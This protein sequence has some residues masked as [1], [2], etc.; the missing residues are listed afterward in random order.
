MFV[1]Y[2][3]KSNQPQKPIT[4]PSDI[5]LSQAVLD[6]SSKGNKK[7]PVCLM[8]EYEKKQFIIAV[9]DPSQS[10]QCPLDLM[11]AAGTEVKFYLKGSGTVHLTGFEYIDDYDDLSMSASSDEDFEDEEIT[12]E[13]EEEEAEPAKKKA[14]ITPKASANK[15]PKG[16]AKKSA[17][18]NGAK[19]ITNGKAKLAGDQPDSDESDED[20]ENFEYPSSLDDDISDEEDEELNDDDD[21]DDDDDDDDE[22][23][24]DEEMDELGEL[25]EESDE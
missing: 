6:P 13:E 24:D 18:V 7:E 15:S 8:A 3:I 5:K 9:L 4:L 17:K 11:F 21:E 14:A 1:G 19:P 22:D 23:D 12:S 16:S 25:D 10:W 20:D 2:E